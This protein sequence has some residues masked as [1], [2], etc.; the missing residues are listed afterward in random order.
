MSIY[1][2]T[3]LSG[4]FHI[5][6]YLGIPYYFPYSKIEI[7]TWLQNV[8]G[9]THDL[10]VETV[11]FDLRAP[12]G[13]GFDGPSLAPLTCSPEDLEAACPAL[14]YCRGGIGRVG[15]VR[16][17][18]I[19]DFIRRGFVVFAPCYR[20]NEGGEGR[21]EFGGADVADV[22]SAYELLANAPFVKRNHITLLGFS[23]GSINAT[24]AAVQVKVAHRLILWGGVSNLAATY[25]ER[26][27]L[28]RMLKRVIG[29]TPTR[30]PESYRMRSPICYASQLNL[31]VLIVHGTNDIQVDVSH[32]VG[33]FHCLKQL[34][35][36][37]TFH[38][39]ERLGHHLP[40]QIHQ[41]VVDRMLEWCI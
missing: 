39:Y 35:K 12:Y 7:Q 37:V 5:K 19:E 10:A 22:T 13:A 3:Y 41:A 34:D 32:G 25:E 29:G 1:R 26:T 24:L 33:M 28:R 40:Y 27:D 14:I 11:S 4:G 6:G 17:E 30:V 23:R 15:K 18:W 21:D 16:L 8:Y 9:N 2:I 38:C 31:P 20:G 36:P